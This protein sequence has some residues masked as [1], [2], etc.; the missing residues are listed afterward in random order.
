[1][2]S[3]K[4]LHMAIARKIQPSPRMQSI[5]L[6]FG[7]IIPRVLYFVAGLTLFSVLLI[8]LFVFSSTSPRGTRK[9]FTNQSFSVG[10]DLTSSYGY[11]IRLVYSVHWLN[12]NSTVAISYPNGSTISVA[13]NDGDNTYRSMMLRLSLQSAEHLQYASCCPNFSSGKTETATVNRTPISS[14]P[15]AIRPGNGNAML[16][17]LWAFLLQ[18]MWAH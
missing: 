15:S 4:P 6:W 5:K 12:T 14:S 8:I 11:A 1:M 16:A 17:N 10:F 18:K 7:A 3:I 9:S 13:K 2:Q